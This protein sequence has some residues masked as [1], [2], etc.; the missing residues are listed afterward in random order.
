MRIELVISRLGSASYNPARMNSGRMDLAFYDRTGRGRLIVTGR[1]RRDLLH[2][3]ASNSLLDLAPGKGVSTCF[4]TQKGRIIDWTIVL[5]RGED[6]LLL[7]GNYDRLSGHIQQFTITE[8]VTVRNYM[9]I[10]LVVCGPDAKK[11]LGVELEPWTFVEKPLAGV[12]VQITRIEPLMGDAYSILAPDAVALRRELGEQGRVLDP[13][14]IDEMRI[15]AVI[16]AWPNE[17]NENQNPWEVGLDDAI[18][19]N[20]GCYVGQEIIAR[21]ST[22][23]KVQRRLRRVRLKEALAEGS[24]LEQDGKE[25]ARLTTVCG[26]RALALVKSG[27][28]EPGTD[29]G[30][31]VVEA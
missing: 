10:E 18:A 13:V 2:R 3:L 24:V 23:D 29:L 14:D 7:A 19:L 30:N 11:F 4:Q 31:A 6:L 9:A 12:K 21:L 28:A 1:E 17:I 5:D 27:L 15:D 16:P 25:V 20:K 22:Y 8:D 26:L